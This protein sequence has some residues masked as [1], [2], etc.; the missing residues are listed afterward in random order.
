MTNRSLMTLFLVLALLPLGC[1]QDSTTNANDGAGGAAGMGGTAMGGAGGTGGVGGS[2][3]PV[4]SALTIA[5]APAEFAVDD[6]AQLTATASYDGGDDSDQTQAVTWTS[7]D[8]QIAAFDENTPGLLR[9]VAPGQV[10]VTATLG[11][12]SSDGLEVAL[13]RQQAF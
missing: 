1:E 2:V 9:A 8:P 5:G 12:V 6:E 10:T 7:S 3:D 13:P 11:D 4:L